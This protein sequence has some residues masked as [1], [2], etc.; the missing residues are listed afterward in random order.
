M[1]RLT[2]FL[3]SSTGEQAPTQYVAYLPENLPL[4]SS[5]VIPI[6]DPGIAMAEGVSTASAW[7]VA[8]T[9]L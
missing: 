9:L 7:W 8:L 2:A 4:I 3:F 6:V 1:T 5:A